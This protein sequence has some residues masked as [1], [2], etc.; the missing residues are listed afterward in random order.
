MS[1]Q[2][3]IGA[4]VAFIAVCGIG[5]VVLQIVKAIQRWRQRGQ[6]DGPV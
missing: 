2:E 1:H 6:Y 3:L 5:L 4:H